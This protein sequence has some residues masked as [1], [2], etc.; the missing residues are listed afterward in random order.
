MQN[1]RHDDRHDALTD[2]PGGHGT[3]PSHGRNTV[4]YRDERKRRAAAESRGG[5]AGR[6][7]P[8]VGKPFDRIGDRSYVDDAAASTGKN[9]VVDVQLKNGGG[10]HSSGHPSQENEHGA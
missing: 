1:Q 5:Q 2:A 7:S 9:S 3:G 6:Q 8:L 10:E 4:A